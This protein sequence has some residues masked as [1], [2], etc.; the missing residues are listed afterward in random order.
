MGPSALARI[1][2]APAPPSAEKQGPR[3]D[4]LRRLAADDAASRASGEYQEPWDAQP[5]TCYEV[6]AVLSSNPAGA[7]GGVPNQLTRK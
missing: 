5:D 1:Q 6:D 7:A 2:L 3:T 4:R